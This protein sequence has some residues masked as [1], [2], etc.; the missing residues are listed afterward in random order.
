M[1]AETDAD[2]V[3][4][5]PL[6]DPLELETVVVRIQAPE[7]VR[8]GSLFLH[9]GGKP[10]ESLPELLRDTRGH[11]DS[12][13]GNTSSSGVRSS[14]AMARRT[15]SAIRSHCASVVASNCAAHA[16]SSAA[17]ASRRVAMAS[18]TSAGSYSMAAM[19]C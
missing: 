19:A 3:N 6:A 9:G 18:W 12:R 17:S 8:P 15:I 10:S 5:L 1:I 4:R 14:T 13:G 2:G 11:E 7:G 16:C